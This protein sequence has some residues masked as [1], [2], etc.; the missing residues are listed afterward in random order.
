L[1]KLF[2]LIF[3]LGI[4]GVFAENI[5]I[6]RVRLVESPGEAGAPYVMRITIGQLTFQCVDLGT[7]KWL[8]DEWGF[9]AAAVIPENKTALVGV[10]L[11]DIL[12]SKKQPITKMGPEAFEFLQK[13]WE[14]DVLAGTKKIERWIGDENSFD[15]NVYFSGQEDNQEFT[16]IYRYYFED[17]HLITLG[18]ICDKSLLK[19]TQSVYAQ[20]NGSFVKYQPK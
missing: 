9:D 16:G 17:G 19:E 20:F 12:D 8:R 4:I 14:A 15:Q 13:R 1:L 18:M 6:D 11:E 7:W 3:S 10:R 5:F 2:T